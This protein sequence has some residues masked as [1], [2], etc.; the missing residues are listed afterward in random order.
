MESLINNLHYNKQLEYRG[1]IIKENHKD[2]YLE[3]YYS[4]MYIERI[5][6]TWKS[7]IKTAKA[8]VDFLINK[9]KVGV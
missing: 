4:N 7:G 9:N 1:F 5:F 8:R 6:S 2:G 3:I